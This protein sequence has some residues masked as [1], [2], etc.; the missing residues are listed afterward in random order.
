MACTNHVRF[1]AN[2]ATDSVAPAPSPEPFPGMVW[3]PGGTF[4]MGSDKHYPEERPAHSVTVDGFW[5]DR[6]PVTNTRFQRFV[7]ATNHVT[8]APL[9]P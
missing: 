1:S 7:A 8:F 2:I 9:F 5:I 3:I 6:Y 4:Q